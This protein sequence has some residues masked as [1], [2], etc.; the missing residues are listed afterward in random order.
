MSSAVVALLSILGVVVGAFLQNYLA[1]QNNE[2]KQ[3]LDSRNQAYVDFLEAVSL[4]VAAQRLGKKEQEIEQLARLTHAKARICIFGEESVVR[5]LA[6]FW[7]AGASL[8]TE[9]EILAFT[10]F[11]L[12]IRRSLGLKDKELLIGEVSQLLFAIK[13]PRS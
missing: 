12:D 4:V 6:S 13:P 1:K 2:S 10:R 9:S 8:E 11:C 7:A 5:K 3:L